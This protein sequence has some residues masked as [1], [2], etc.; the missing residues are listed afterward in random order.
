L[1]LYANS[2]NEDFSKEFSRKV[3]LVNSLLIYGRILCLI[4]GFS[5]KTDSARLNIK[6]RANP[7]LIP[8]ETLPVKPFIVIG[9][10]TYLPTTQSKSKNSRFPIE[11]SKK[12]RAISDSSLAL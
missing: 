1:Y 4:S 12:G 6:K 10:F 5:R 7:F 2:K 8:F 9:D 11:I 3:D